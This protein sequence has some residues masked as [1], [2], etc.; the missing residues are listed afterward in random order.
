MTLRKPKRDGMR[1]PARDAINYDVREAVDRALAFRPDSE[2]SVTKYS[3]LIQCR[4]S[5]QLQRR[6]VTAPGA[7]TGNSYVLQG[8]IR[9]GAGL[10]IEVQ[11]IVDFVAAD[12]AAA[13]DCDMSRD[14]RQLRPDRYI[15]AEDDFIG[16]VRSRAIRSRFTAADICGFAIGFVDGLRQGA[17]VVDV[18]IGGKSRRKRRERHNDGES[19]LPGSGGVH[20]E[21]MRRSQPGAKSGGGGGKCK[22]LARRVRLRRYS[23]NRRV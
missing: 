5:P 3:Y 1:P 14:S 8:Q 16:A 23:R 17:G 7:A 20:D 18:D 6:L 12:A 15:R 13:V 9:I 19:D 2:K 11:I 21:Q 10:N 22:E 4:R